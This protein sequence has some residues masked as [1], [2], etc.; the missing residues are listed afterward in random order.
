MH[1]GGGHFDE[2]TF[3][4]ELNTPSLNFGRTFLSKLSV[5][6]LEDLGYDTFLNN[7]FDP[8]DQFGPTPGN[9]VTDDAFL[10]A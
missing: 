9:S 1:G 8:N 4:A 3:G 2:R 10:I 6:T 7:P 5:A